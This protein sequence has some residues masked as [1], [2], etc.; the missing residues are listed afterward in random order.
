MIYR[1]FFVFKIN[2]RKINQKERTTRIE[3]VLDAWEAPVLPL[4]HARNIYV[5]IITGFSIFTNVFLYFSEFYEYSELFSF[6]VSIQYL[7]AQHAVQFFVR[8]SPQQKAV[9][10][11]F[12][13][14][15]YH[16]SF[17]LPLALVIRFPAK[18]VMSKIT[19]AKAAV[20]IATR[21]KP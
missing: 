3:L 17:I 5:S 20:R 7:A 10:V 18:Y 9:Q 11:C 8:A 6:F 15:S 13:L 1:A 21:V 16:F 4:N 19:I 14:N 12:V 2:W